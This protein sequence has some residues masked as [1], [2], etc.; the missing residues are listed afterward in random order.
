MTRNVNIPEKERREIIKWDILY[1]IIERLIKE[2][3]RKK[4]NWVRGSINVMAN[5]KKERPIIV[6]YTAYFQGEYWV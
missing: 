6:E 5:V 3:G 4:K 2:R 1:K